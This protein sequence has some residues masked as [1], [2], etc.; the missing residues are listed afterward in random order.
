MPAPLIAITADL[1]PRDSGPAARVA[2]A[3]ANRVVAAGGVP[4]VLVPTDEHPTN[5]LERFDG[6]ILTGGDD[7]RTEPFGQPTDAR[8]TPVLEPRQRFESWLLSQLAAER[9]AVPIFGICLG[10]QMMALHA[11]GSLHQHLPE[12]HPKTHADHWQGEHEILPE[13]GVPE[14]QL[15][16][17]VSHS[18]HKQAVHDPGSLSVLARAPDGLVEAVWDPARPFHLGVQWHPERTESVGL[19][20]HLFDRFVAASL[21]SRS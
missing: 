14:E 5:L 6:F 2:M 8:I 4:A 10:M 19:G 16:R 17:G 12:S 15:S 9:P 1:Y 18:H 20:Q 11:G 7:P 13:P 21:A 3:Y